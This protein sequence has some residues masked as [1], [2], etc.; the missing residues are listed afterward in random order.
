VTTDHDQ[1]AAVIAAELRQV[2]AEVT[3][4]RELTGLPAQTH[5]YFGV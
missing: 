4:R 5:G 1:H 2:L 3:G